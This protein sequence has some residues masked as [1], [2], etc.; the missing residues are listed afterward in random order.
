MCYLSLGCPAPTVMFV[1]VMVLK[2]CIVNERI[3]DLTTR[4]LLVEHNQQK[5]LD[6]SGARAIVYNYK[7]DKETVKDLHW[8]TIWVN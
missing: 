6:G 1:T 8:L 4:R 5:E 7:C 3:N 2:K